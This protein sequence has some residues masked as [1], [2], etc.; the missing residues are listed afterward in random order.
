MTVT[1]RDII[2]LAS[3]EAGI[4]GVGQTLLAEDTNDTF[5]LLKRMIAQ[6]QRRRW[7]VPSLIDVSMNGNGNVSNQI[8][9]NQFWNVPRPDK[10][11]G[12]YII[13]LNTG[14]TPVS[15]PLYPVFSYED[16]IQITVKNLNSLPTHF[17]Y[18][19]K[20]PVGNVFIWPVPTST[21][22]MHLLIKSQ[23]GL[24]TTI[25][26]VAANGADGGSITNPGEGYTNGVY[27]VVPL[28]PVNYGTLQGQSVGTGAT[29][30]I[31]VAGG[32][33]T[34]CV[35]DNGGES[36]NTGDILTS[37]NTYIGGT[38]AGFTYTVNN[39][40]ANLDSTIDMPPEYEEPL[41]YNL[42]LRICS[43]YQIQATDDTK[44][45]A[46]AGLNTIRMANT[47]VPQL[48][49]PPTLRRGKAFNIYNADGF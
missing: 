41:H 33:V 9:N 11:Q 17:F 46:K 47:Q 27:N 35:L 43:M 48:L 32:V 5:I 49:M 13:Q 6:W 2:T 36:F 21:Y 7:L 25:N 18:D 14:S 20:Y 28:V 8:G 30:N 3:K 10:I 26:T 40:T 16:Y 12:G 37:P 31:T 15:L 45:L 1:A 29:A 4:L 22:E 34:S 39:T 19:A 44:K 38:G 42:A 24:A 23:L